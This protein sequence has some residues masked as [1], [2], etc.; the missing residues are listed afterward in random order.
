MNYHRTYQFALNHTNDLNRKYDT[1]HEV[2]NF[3]LNPHTQW[4]TIQF[5]RILAE[6]DTLGKSYLQ[7]SRLKL[8]HCTVALIV[9]QIHNPHS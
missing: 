5:Q 7:Y 4:N 8:V 9:P 3:R 2:K 1:I 6:I